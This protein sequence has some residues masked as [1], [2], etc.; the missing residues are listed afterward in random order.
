MAGIST[1]NTT[2]R[3][4]SE[5]ARHMTQ[6]QVRIDGAGFTPSADNFKV[7]FDDTAVD[8]IPD[9]ST[10]TAS[11]TIA[12]TLKASPAGTISGLFTIPANKQTGTLTIKVANAT[13]QA[14][15]PYTQSA[16]TE[17]TEIVRNR[18]MRGPDPDIS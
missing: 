6:K 13:E 9:T 5:T 15:V 7:T 1:T 2:T 11:G 4:Y 17:V 12:G 3:V 10:A 16:T 14:T 8:A 18:V